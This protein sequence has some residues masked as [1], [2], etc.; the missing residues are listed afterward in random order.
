MRLGVYV[1]S[2]D[3][4]HKGHIKV[5]NYLLENDYVDKV[6]VI[7]TQDYWHKKNI[8]DLS[9]RLNMLKKYA[10][11]NIIIDTDCNNYQFTYEI[12]NELKNRY[13]QTELKLI[14]GSD[15]LASFHKWQ[16]LDELLKYPI[17]VL[18]RGDFEAN[19]ISSPFVLVRDFT[20][21]NI[22]SSFIRQEISK[23]HFKNLKEYLD[24]PI[25]DY[26]LDH[27]LYGGN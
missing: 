19:N 11:D 23:K 22:S 21:L 26:I 25:I 20:Y 18:P 2:F 6:L 14:I 4:V 5:I 15:H 3:P 9:D 12:L 13:P 17:L 8:T 24:Q 10:N 16:H 27:N 1:G 7:A